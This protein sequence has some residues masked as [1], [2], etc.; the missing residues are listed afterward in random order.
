MPRNI[1]IMGI[2]NT[3]DDSYFSDSRCSDN[4]AVLRRAEKMVKDGVDIF[5]IG[6][7]STRPGSVT[8]DLEEE[9]N[10]LKDAI[11]AIRKEFPE[12]PVSID[13]FRSEIVR[14][15]YDSIGEHT[16]NDISAG[17]ADCD[18]LKTAGE[19]K[20]PYI[21]M[22]M[23]GTPQTMSGLCQYD[24]ITE[25]IIS[26][27]RRFEERMSSYGIE[28]YIL[29]PGFGFAKT[30]EQNYELLHNLDRFR[31]LGRQ[32]L[33]GVSRKSMIFRL[34]NITPQEALPATQ[35]LHMEALIRGADI[36]R[37]HD[38]AEARQCATIYNMMY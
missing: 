36:L 27:F 16:I 5:D 34:F 10:R 14:R 2:I 9:W 7:C 24:N 3:T 4:A 29:D 31:C 20:L 30:I 25:D 38:V 15:A 26:Y 11:P 1:K 6:G 23:R 32:I 33:V 37:V 21:A 28:D 17:E 12:I 13:T 22:H 18:M 19:L 35:A 8:V